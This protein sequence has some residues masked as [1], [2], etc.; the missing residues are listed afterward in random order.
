MRPELEIIE[1]YDLYIRQRK[2]ENTNVSILLCLAL[3]FT[4]LPPQEDR[5]RLIK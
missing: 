3:K 2:R 1:L 4:I 5:I